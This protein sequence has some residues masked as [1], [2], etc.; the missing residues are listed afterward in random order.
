MSEQQHEFTLGTLA[1]KWE[2]GEIA[3]KE[4]LLHALMWMQSLVTNQALTERSLERLKREVGEF[5]EEQ[6]K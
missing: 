5:R 6:E 3:E 2:K 1:A 4:L